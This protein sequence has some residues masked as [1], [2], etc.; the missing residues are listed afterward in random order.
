MRRAASFALVA[1]VGLVGA[2]ASGA[3]VADVRVAE[4][5]HGVELA[6]RPTPRG[7]WSPIGPVDDVTL[8]SEGD[9][10]GD[11]VPG[12][13]T[14]AARLVAAWARPI[15][16]SVQL[17]SFE[18]G[19]WAARAEIPVLATGAPRVFALGDDDFV[20][21]ARVLEPSVETV[22]A[23]V[24][25]DAASGLS[26]GPDLRLE[27]R[28]IDAAVIGESLQVVLVEEL[29][30]DAR[31]TIAVIDFLH[32]P[33]E[34]IEPIERI[35]VEV[36]TLT[37]MLVDVVWS[38]TPN[39]PI[40]IADRI[41]VEVSLSRSESFS[42]DALPMGSG[43][44]DLP[45]LLEAVRPR[46]LTDRSLP[47]DVAV[48]AWWSGARELSF[49]ELTEV[50]PIHPVQAVSVEHGPERPGRLVK[51]ALRLVSERY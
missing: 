35:R 19:R 37:A 17:A 2:L 30:R 27:G 7:P 34:P 44:P 48:L 23:G 41:P 6:V 33:G 24:R 9:L 3:A 15:D 39:P 22:L 43:A 40:D 21:V 36:G 8:N 32:V 46:L 16:A 1:L 25:G 11:G 14:S 26:T 18:G 13:A 50:G 12:A 28:L 45:D 51:E 38:I 10:I 31:F 4:R 29:D 5:A 49:I 47:S 42:E 20:V